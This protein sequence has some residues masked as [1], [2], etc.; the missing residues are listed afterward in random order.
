MLSFFFVEHETTNVGETCAGRDDYYIKKLKPELGMEFENEHIAY[1]FYNT[2]AGHVGFSVRKSWH[3][4]SSK[5][6]LFHL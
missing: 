4:K 3:D 5:V 1:E 2:Y 6:L